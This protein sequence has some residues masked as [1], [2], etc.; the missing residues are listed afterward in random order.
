MSNPTAPTLKMKIVVQAAVL[1]AAF[2]QGPFP[3]LTPDCNKA[4]AACNLKPSCFTVIR[5]I[6]YF[7]HKIL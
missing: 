1:V 7:I 4:Y 3:Q 2:G 5:C 6:V